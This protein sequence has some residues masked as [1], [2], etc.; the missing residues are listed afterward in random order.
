MQL[1]GGR[2]LDKLVGIGDAMAQSSKGLDWRFHTSCRPR[3]CL[4]CTRL[5]VEGSRQSR[6]IVPFEDLGNLLRGLWKRVILMS[7]KCNYNRQCN[8]T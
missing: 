2:T 1:I 5:V 4:I 6:N 8:L 7:S 3:W